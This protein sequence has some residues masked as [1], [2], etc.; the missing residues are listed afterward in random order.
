M[1]EDSPI[2]THVREF[3]DP[4]GA[5]VAACLT[6][7]LSDGFSAVYSFCTP[8]EPARS[9]GNFVILRLVERA[10]ESGLPYVYLGYW[11]EESPKMA[12]KSRFRPLEALY[13]D[14]WRPFHQP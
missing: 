12:Y 9:L 3:R 14:G 13:G 10:R 8:D 7:R 5:L 2:D 1:V 4:S 6:D 11:I